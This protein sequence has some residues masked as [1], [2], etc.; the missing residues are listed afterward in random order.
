MKYAALMNTVLPV[1]QQETNGVMSVIGGT[2]S[3]RSEAHSWGSDRTVR[4]GHGRCATLLQSLAGAQRSM[5]LGI[6]VGDGL[7]LQAFVSGVA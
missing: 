7:S 3:R 4:E 1:L 2:I 5:G 6:R